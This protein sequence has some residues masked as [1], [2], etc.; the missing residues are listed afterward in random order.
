[1]RQPEPVMVL[2]LGLI[3]GLALAC[4]AGCATSALD[5][6]PAHPDEPWV[7]ATSASGSAPAGYVLPP[8]PDLANVP[9]PVLVESA[10]VY[11]LP[12]LIDIAQS[13]NPLTRIAWND[14]RRI[15]LGAGIAKSAY[16]PQL[17]ASAIGGYQVSNGHDV[18]PGTPVLGSG[19]ASGAV[20]AVS[21]QWLLFDFGG[22]AAVV[23]MATQAS[24]I[25]NIAFTAAHQQVIYAVS[26]TFYAQAAAQARV[27]T[28]EQSFQ[29]SQAIQS[30]AQA[31][32]QHGVG[33]V[34]EV[35]QARLGLAQAELARV[36][37]AGAAQ[38]A[39]LALLTAMGISPLTKI[40]IA[41]VSGRQL[42][43][44]LPPP[45]QAVV[46]QAVSRRPDVQS[47]F[48]AEEASVAHVRAARAQFLPKIF[49]AGNATYSSAGLDVTAL[50]AV[51]QQGPTVNVS[52]SRFGGSIFAGFTV[53]LYDGGMRAAVLDQAKAEVDSAQAWSMRVKEDAVR[54]IVMADN[55]LRTS[56][57]AFHAAESLAAAAQTNFDAGLAAYR[58]G[59]GS[60]TDVSLAETQLLQARNASSDAYS[61]ALAAAASLALACGTPG[62]AP[63]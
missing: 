59:V 47:A 25:S 2:T 23:D 57:S 7:P 33:T 20:A 46:A 3:M 17:S 35:D 10:K 51:G 38:D 18:A 40:R 1:M 14:A 56:L 50:P 41:D 44:S 24:M 22:R 9:P 11:S 39:Q 45:A 34:I 21:L 16:L 29:D 26:E 5:L 6:A 28:A 60:G 52:G 12:E 4:V 53:P 48:A 8:D 32:Y 27:A 36:Q 62:A 58:N 15:A 55:A 49:L 43:P 13:S 37:A 61:A 42:P 63:Q 19:S 30:A 31:R 54:Q